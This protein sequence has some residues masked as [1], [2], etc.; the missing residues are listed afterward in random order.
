MHQ[1]KVHNLMMVIYENIKQRI[2]NPKRHW[3]K[4]VDYGGSFV[5]AWDQEK[6]PTVQSVW[7][8]EYDFVESLN[9]FIESRLSERD[10][11]K[12]GLERFQF[13]REDFISWW[14]MPRE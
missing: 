4:V 11:M 6:V 2:I 1:P 10:R 3:N 9:E 13:H 5:D 12:L 7:C 14:S 8:L